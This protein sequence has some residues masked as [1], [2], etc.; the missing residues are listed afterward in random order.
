MLLQG[1]MGTVHFT[2]LNLTQQ[3]GTGQGMVQI[4]A[5]Q[6]ASSYTLGEFCFNFSECQFSHMLKCR[7][8]EMQ[9]VNCQLILVC[10]RDSSFPMPISCIN[11]FLPLLCIIAWCPDSD[12]HRQTLMKGFLLE[13][14]LTTQ[15]T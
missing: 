11:N 3:L 6:L 12:L 1:G 13:K 14:N 15:M 5:P 7:L 2:V 4:L 10:C 8:H 9:G